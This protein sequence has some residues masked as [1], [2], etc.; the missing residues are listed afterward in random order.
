MSNYEEKEA[1]ALAKIADVLNKLDASLEEL[2][3]L[4]EDTKKH[5]MKKW[6]VEKR[7]MH[8][9]KKIAHEAG[10]Y[11][12]YDEKELQKEIEHVEQYM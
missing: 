6:L 3:S 1:Q 7:A 8:E 4:D 5:S 2:G 10:K 12:K 9:I 11:D